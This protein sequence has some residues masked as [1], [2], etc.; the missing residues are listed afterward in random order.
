[1]DDVPL[2]TRAKL[3][4]LH[5]GALAHNA[6]V[7]QEY[8]QSTFGAVV[9]PP[10]RSSDLMLLEFYYSTPLLNVQDL[11]DKI[12]NSCAELQ[13]EPILA[14]TQIERRLQSRM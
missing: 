1:M 14:A 10:P 12:V 11:K 6:I 4:F 3:F 13:R 2:E 9:S 5:D 8:L 7:V